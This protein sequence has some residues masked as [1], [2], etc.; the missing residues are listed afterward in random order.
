MNKNL[1]SRAARKMKRLLIPPEDFSRSYSQQAEDMILRC[2]FQSRGSGFYVDVGAHHPTR[3]SNTRYFYARG[4]RGINI[5]AL[6]GIMDLFKAARP[7]DINLQ[8]G[9]SA[10]AQTL[11][12]YRFNDPAVNGFCLSEDRLKELEPQFKLVDIVPVKTMPLRSILSEHL[13]AGTAIDFLSIDVEGLEMEVLESNDWERFHPT[14]V[15]A[16][17]LNAYT[18]KEVVDSPVT[19]FMSR[20][21]Y[22][23]CAKAPHTIFYLRNGSFTHAGLEDSPK[24]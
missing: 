21:G 2:L 22:T 13:P 7:K 15:L 23:A 10:Q 1:V 3:Y 16:E 11:N 12:Y 19:A 17:D 20:V 6:P 4:W 14:V 8:V 18:L 24:D 5:D 9:V